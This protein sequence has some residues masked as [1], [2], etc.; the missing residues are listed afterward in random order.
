MKRRQKG[1][2]AVVFVLLAGL[3]L[4]AYQQHE[5]AVKRAAAQELTLSDNDDLR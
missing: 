2:L 4:I 1:I 3:G 5:A